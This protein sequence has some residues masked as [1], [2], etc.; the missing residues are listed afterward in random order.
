MRRCNRN[1]Y[2]IGDVSSLVGVSA[3]TLRN[4]ERKGLVTP[5]RSK[6]GHRMYAEEDVQRLFRTAVF[7]RHHGWNPAA[8]L[9]SGG[10]DP[11]SPAAVHDSLGPMVRAVRLSAGRTLADVAR[12]TQLSES[13]LSALERGETGASVRSVS[14]IADALGVPQSAFS[15]GPNPSEKY[16][17]RAGQRK[18]TELEGGTRY[19]EL[20]VPGYIL[21]PSLLVVPPGQGSGGSY[22]RH[23]ES[24][25]VVLQGWLEFVVDRR[26][27]EGEAILLGDGDSAMLPSTGSWSWHNPTDA[28]TRALWVEVLGGAG[29]TLKDRGAKGSGRSAGS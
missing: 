9:A 14:Q 17:V 10:L 20:A 8:I 16:V 18:I 26:E 2:T 6:G 23:A 24:F 27:D 7:R 3:Q 4:W 13:F 21:E 28:E 19:E 29:S 1:H 5:S 12:E 15:S 25:V 11:A 22:S